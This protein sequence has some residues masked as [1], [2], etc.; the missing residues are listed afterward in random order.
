MA[1]A[2]NSKLISDLEAEVRV[3]AM[4][5]Q[6]HDRESGPWV[7]A[8]L[9][10]RARTPNAVSR[11]RRSERIIRVCQEIHSALLFCAFSLV[12]KALSSDLKTF[13]NPELSLEAALAEQLVEGP[14]VKHRECLFGVEK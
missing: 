12:I 6:H 13:A 9:P 7:M 10:S 2:T 3:C 14:S 5:K 4:W 8:Q 1:W 11:T